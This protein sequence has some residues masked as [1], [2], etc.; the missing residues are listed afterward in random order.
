M[1][2]FETT[3]E[4]Y[5]LYRE[6]YPPNFFVAVARQLGFQGS[7][8]LIDLGTGP[9]MLALGFRPFVASILGVDPE[10]AMLAAAR[11]AATAAHVEFPLFAGRTEDLP[12]DIGRF[13][14]VTIGRALH[15]MDKATSLPVLDRLLLPDGAIL[16]CGCSPAKDGSNPWLDI[17]ERIVHSW[18]AEGAT[19]WNRIYGNWF[20]GSSF[21]PAGEI[22]TTFTQPITPQ[23]LCERALTRST[24][25]PAILGSRIDACRAELL[26]ALVPFFPEG[27]RQ[28]TLKVRAEI[29]RRG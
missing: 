27:S 11:E 22:E 10:P 2:R 7:E 15:W 28:E 4:T 19:N 12:A 16:V 1:G 29:L 24:T 8:A 13:D 20:V 9:G 18:A 5:A 17:L 26:T 21:L 23:A 6:P 25:S 3:A 14:L